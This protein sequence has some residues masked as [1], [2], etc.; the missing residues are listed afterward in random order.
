M[1][2][3][4]TKYPHLQSGR[5]KIIERTSIRDACFACRSVKILVMMLL[6]EKKK[7]E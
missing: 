2:V 5:A 1:S 3:V 6:L 7:K 4:H